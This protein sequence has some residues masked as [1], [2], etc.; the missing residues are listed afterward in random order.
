MRA[1]PR[2]RRGPHGKELLLAVLRAHVAKL[3][4]EAGVPEDMIQEQIWGRP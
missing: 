3:M 2:Q 4:R 1:I